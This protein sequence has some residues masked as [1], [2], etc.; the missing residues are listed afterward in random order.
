MARDDICSLGR[1]DSRAPPPFP[2]SWVPHLVTAMHPN[3]GQLLHVD[4]AKT[5]GQ[6]MVYAHDKKWQWAERERYSW[7]FTPIA[8]PRKAKSAIAQSTEQP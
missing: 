4:E 2:L 1:P 6:I 3:Q 7:R 8:L 5:W